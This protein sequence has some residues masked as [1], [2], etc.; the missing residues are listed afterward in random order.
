MKKIKKQAVVFGLAFLCVVMLCVA[1]IPLVSQ[2]VK[3]CKCG[4]GER[5]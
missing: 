4:N 5:Q 2:I 3:P 1:L